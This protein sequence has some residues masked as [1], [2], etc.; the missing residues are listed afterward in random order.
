MAV[1]Q[2]R[3]LFLP[4]DHAVEKGDQETVGALLERFLAG[5]A[6]APDEAVA[7]GAQDCQPREASLEGDHQVTPAAPGHRS[8][9]GPTAAGR[10]ALLGEVEQLALVGFG[11][12]QDSPA[13]AGAGKLGGQPGVAKRG[14][15]VIEPVKISGRDVETEKVMPRARPFDGSQV[16]EGSFE[17]IT[18]ECPRPPPEPGEALGLAAG[19]ASHGVEDASVERRGFD[20]I[21]VP[22]QKA[23]IG[24]VPAELDELFSVRDRGERAAARNWELLAGEIVA[25]PGFERGEVSR[26][27]IDLAADRL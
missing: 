24:L 12:E 20:L 2:L 5:F 27:Q 23:G 25:V 19:A 17:I 26:H 1:V 7:E 6:L 18:M 4:L 13:V 3:W 8:V 21:A 10:I 11:I 14:D 16:V 22:A 15:V 9:F